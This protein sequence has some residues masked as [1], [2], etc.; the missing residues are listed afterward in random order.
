MERY[1]KLVGK[2]ILTL[3]S[4]AGLLGIFWLSLPWLLVSFTTQQ[5]EVRGFSNIEFGDVKIGLHNAELESLQ[6]SSDSMDFAVGQVAVS[7]H[8]PRLMSANLSSIS[9]DTMDIVSNE[10]TS[11]NSSSPDVAWL[12]G[13]LAMPWYNYLPA[14]QINVHQ[15]TFSDEASGKSTHAS[16]QLPR[17]ENELHATVNLD[18]GENR[19]HKLIATLSS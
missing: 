13:L 10:S 11:S 16:I 19:S 4:V 5:L 1:V 12:A 2:L 6:L 8:L 17:A 18:S 14:D 15:F 3:L 7:Y 9:V